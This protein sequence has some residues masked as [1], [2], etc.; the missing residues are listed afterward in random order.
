MKRSAKGADVLNEAVTRGI[1][2][3]AKRTFPNGEGVA[4]PLWTPKLTKLDKMVQECKNER[5]RDALIRWRRKVL[6]DTA[7]ARWKENAS[8][9]SATESVSLNLAKSIYAP[10]PLTS[11]VLVVDGHPLTKR[12]QAQAL[13][14]IHMARS[15]KALHAPEMKIPSTRRSTFRHITEAELE[16]ALRELSSSTAPGDDNARCEELSQLGRAA[17]KCVLR[18]FNCSLRTGQVPAKWRQGIIVPLLKPNKPANSVASFWPVTLTSTLRKLMERIAV[19]GVR[20][21][22]ED[23]LKPQRPGFRPAR[24]TLGTLMQVTSAAWRRKDGEKTAACSLTTRVPS[25]QLTMT[26]LSRSFCHLALGGI[27]RCGARAFCRST[28]RRC[29]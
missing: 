25:I 18:L 5:K 10:R 23:K 3:T 26:A 4:P 24:S 8:K 6:A 1:Q 2:T 7:L 21:C 12:Q 19:R 20:D 13:A 15:T 16:V 22:I 29:G 28:R 17:M 11:P 27:C 9:F 14:N